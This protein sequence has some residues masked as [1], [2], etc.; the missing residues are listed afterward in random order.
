MASHPFPQSGPPTLSAGLK[1]KSQTETVSPFLHTQHLL[2]LSNHA[3]SHDKSSLFP[4]SNQ[5]LNPTPHTPSPNSFM[6][7]DRKQQVQRPPHFGPPHL[8]QLGRLDPTPVPSAV[9][10]AGTPGG[11]AGSPVPP[12][13]RVI[14]R[15][16]RG[17]LPWVSGRVAPPPPVGR[18]CGRWENRRVW[19]LLPW[20][21]RAGSGARGGR[22]RGGARR[23]AGECAEL[24]RRSMRGPGRPAPAHSRGRGARR[25]AE[26]P[27][28]TDCTPPG[29]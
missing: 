28:Y 23:G 2:I 13:A 4:Q 21:G 9:P 27:V 1:K 26:K 7:A 25:G 20:G 8:G 15:A 11:E 22:G 29:E 5:T 18:G 17:R 3:P 12:P 10:S 14:A 6:P 24:R 16:R 19:W